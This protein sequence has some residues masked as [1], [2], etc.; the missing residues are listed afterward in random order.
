M[1]PSGVKMR[2][3]LANKLP[4]KD[5]VSQSARLLESRGFGVTPVPVKGA[6]Y[7]SLTVRPRLVATHRDGRCVVV[8]V[9][10]VAERFGTL[11]TLFGDRAA[12]SLL[13]A[14]DADYSIELHCWRR[15][16]DG[17]PKVE[18]TEITADDFCSGGQAH[19]LLVLL[20]A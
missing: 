3:K 5:P 7:L 14:G 1:Y 8:I 10:A 4:V 17:Q 19:A 2:A 11:V 9:T 20:D 18:V 12:A 6:R 15:G 16:A 13:F